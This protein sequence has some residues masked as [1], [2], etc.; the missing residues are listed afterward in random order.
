MI[1]RLVAPLLELDVVEDEELELGRQQALI[2][3]A[4][5]PHVAGGLAGDVPRVAGVVLVGDRIVDVADHR[6]G[7]LRRERVDQGRLGLGDDQQV[8]LVDRAPAH[9]ARAVEADAFL[10]RLLG[11]GIGRDREMLPDAGKIH[12]PQVDRRDLALP[13]LCQDFFGSHATSLLSWLIRS[14]RHRS[15]AFDRTAPRYG[16]YPGVRLARKVDATETLMPTLQL[17]ATDCGRCPTS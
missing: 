3:H 2:G 7:R 12:E 16:H 9:D 13:D 8:G 6:Q 11:E 1:E 17:G 14:S 5:V 10:E 4:R 15:C